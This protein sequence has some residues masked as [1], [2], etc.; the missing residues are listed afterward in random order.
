MILFPFRYLWWLVSSVRRL[1]GK[2]PEFVLFLLED[3][4]PVLP[5]PPRPFWQRFAGRRRL[6]VKELG[7]RF[8][9]IARDSRIKG[10]VLHLRPVAI[11]M[12]TYTG[13]NFRSP[14]I[15]G[16]DQPVSLVG[17]AVPFPRTAADRER[18]G[19]PRRSVAERYASREAYLAKARDVNAALVKQGY[20][21]AED[22]AEVMKRMEEHW[23]LGES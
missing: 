16:T 15:G 21:L 5:D 2:P 10:V 7:D 6:S 12:A 8:D 3:S 4:M 9:A 17:S 19:D 13:W 1:I 14:A 20:L 23:R 22:V 11:P 18:A